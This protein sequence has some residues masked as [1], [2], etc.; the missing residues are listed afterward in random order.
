MRELY[1]DKFQNMEKTLESLVNEVKTRPDIIISGDHAHS[2]MKNRSWLNENDEKEKHRGNNNAYD[3]RTRSDIQRPKDI[4]L[5]VLDQEIKA[6]FE[7]L[8]GSSVRE[9]Q[10]KGM[11][12][13]NGKPILED[14]DVQR[15]HEGFQS[16][17]SKQRV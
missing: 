16:K 15:L 2:Y 4:M 14:P 17:L 6:D 1:E 11:T 5:D 10:K 7:A 9:S 3:P 12:Q 8:R 13:Y